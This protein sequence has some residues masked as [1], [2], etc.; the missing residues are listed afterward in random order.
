MSA[1]STA[2]RPPG[3]AAG[4]DVPGLYGFQSLARLIFVDDGESIF[5]RHFEV[6]KQSEYGMKIFNDMAR[7]FVNISTEELEAGVGR[8][9]A[10]SMNYLAARYAS[11]PTA[12]GSVD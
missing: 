3:Y 11:L 6:S 12:A 5:E 10:I 9:D 4:I 7:H 2:P 1:T 8:D